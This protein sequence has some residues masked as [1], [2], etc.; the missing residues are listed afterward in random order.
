MRTGP[1]GRSLFW[2]ISGLFMLAIVL[3]TLVQILV[4]VAVLRP[5]E[6]RE[7]RTRAEL[8]ASG[9]AADLAAAPA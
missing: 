1:R 9:L 4:A 5:L 8:A 2:T 6:A 3:G 7:A